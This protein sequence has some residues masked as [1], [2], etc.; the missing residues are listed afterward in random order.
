MN[1][2]KTFILIGSGLTLLLVI[3]GS[4]LYGQRPVRVLELP[5][6]L[7]NANAPAQSPHSPSAAQRGRTP[8]PAADAVP[9]ATSHNID[10]LSMT[11]PQ[12]SGG[13]SNPVVITAQ[14]SDPAV[15]RNSV[16]LLYVP[17][18]GAPQVIGTLHDDGLNGDATADDNIFTFSTSGLSQ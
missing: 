15:I 1:T 2:K 14:I 9:A 17:A 6:V 18:T 3:G 12:I 11:P 7:Q 10:W 16:N 8:A 4:L 5:Q 13:S